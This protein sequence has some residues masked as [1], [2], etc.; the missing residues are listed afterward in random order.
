MPVLKTEEQAKAWPQKK[1]TETKTKDFPLLEQCSPA[2]PEKNPLLG[3]CLFNPGQ[4]Q[5]FLSRALEQ[6][7]QFWVYKSSSFG[8]L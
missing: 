6:F 3:S 7:F 1:K 2:G 8:G 5:C 4:A